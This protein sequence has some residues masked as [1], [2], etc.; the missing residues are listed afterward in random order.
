MN[1][2]KTQPTYFPSIFDDFFKNTWDINVQ[3]YSFHSPSFNIKENDKEYILEL[4]IPGKN[5]DNF[6]LELDNKLLKVSYK[7][8][9]EDTE[10]NYNVREFNY[11]SFEKSFEIPESIDFNK[12]NSYYREGILSIILPKRKEFQRTAKKIIDV[13]N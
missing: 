13:K 6:K 9:N 5:N 11:S 4:A 3:D 10:Y 2:I 12:I 7:E 1:L 8:D